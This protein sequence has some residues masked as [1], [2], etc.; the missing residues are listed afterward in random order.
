MAIDPIA[1][2]Q[3][4][5]IVKQSAPEKLAL[6]GP[7]LRSFFKRT[8]CKKEDLCAELAHKG[9]LDYDRDI[10]TVSL[11]PP[12]HHLLS[13][14]TLPVP[15]EDYDHW[16]LQRLA[17]KD[18]TATPSQLYKTGVKAEVRD[19]RLLALQEKGLV[20]LET[21]LKTKQAAVWLTDAGHTLVQRWLDSITQGVPTQLEPLDTSI[22]SPSSSTALPSDTDVL[23]LIRKLNDELGSNN[24]LPIFHL[25][26]RLQP[27]FSRQALDQV[28]YRLQQQD[29]IELS[30]LQDTSPY[31]PEQLQS[32][33]Q[34]DFGNPL[35]FISLPQTDD[36][37]T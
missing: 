3:F 37:F 13:L 18:G 10:A 16:L 31:S 1:A 36:L 6:A 17:K 11:L 19:Q 34:Q 35:F 28:L 21:K 8:A 5:L 23:D 22:S 33:I 15:L 12:A 20:Q 32:A 30:T 29:Q 14:P 4:L 24:Y 27:P 25:R 26:Q 9:L 2:A 7:Q